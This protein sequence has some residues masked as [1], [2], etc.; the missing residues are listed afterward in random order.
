MSDLLQGAPRHPKWKQFLYCA[1]FVC[2]MLAGFLTVFSMRSKKADAPDASAED[3]LGTV[4]PQILVDG[5]VYYW[6]GMS[7]Q[8]QGADTAG[9]QVISQADGKTYLPEG[10]TEYGAFLTSVGT[11]P[12]EDLQMQADFPAFGTVYRNPEA[13][14]VIYILIT[15][16]WFESEY[17]RFAS[18]EIFDGGRIA[19]GGKQYRAAF[20]L[21]VQSFLEELP[22]GAVAV[23]TLQYIGQDYMPQNDLETNIPCDNYAYSLEGRE[24]FADPKD[25]DHIYV[26]ATHYWS[27][28][29][30]GVYWKCPLWESSYLPQSVK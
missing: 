1:A 9:M 12:T 26:Y 18:R 28:G 10:F 15:T 11:P 30:Y 3:V 29:S 20:Q 25:P 21:E 4:T 23:G 6:S 5:T 27:G 22:K 24:V 19:W 8:K 17:V 14:E 13:P 7:Q 2:L 16:D